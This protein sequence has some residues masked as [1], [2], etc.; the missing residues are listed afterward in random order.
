MK[1]PI[2]PEEEFFG[3]QGLPPHLKEAYEELNE[4]G[5]SEET[6]EEFARFSLEV[7]KYHSTRSEE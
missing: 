3:E 4:R 5:Y 6:M 7:A 2:I 1:N